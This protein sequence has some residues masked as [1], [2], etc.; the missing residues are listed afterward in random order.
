MDYIKDQNSQY[1]IASPWKALLDYIYCYKKDWK[2]MDPLVE[3]LRIEFEELPKINKSQLRDFELFYKNHR[4][5]QF[6]RNI[7]AELLNEH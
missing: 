6:I 4:I 5:R 2:N 7:P 1:L 3:S